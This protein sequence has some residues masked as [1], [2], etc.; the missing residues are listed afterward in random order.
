[1]FDLNIPQFLSGLGC[2]ICIS[3]SFIAF[4]NF[5]KLSTSVNVIKKVCAGVFLIILI[6]HIIYACLEYYGSNK[7]VMT[8]ALLCSVSLRQKPMKPLTLKRR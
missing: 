1:M 8:K 3:I 2:G 5:N 4:R 7:A 6:K